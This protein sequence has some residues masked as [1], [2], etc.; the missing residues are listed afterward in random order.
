MWV[1]F[2]CHAWISARFRRTMNHL[3]YRCLPKQLLIQL[4][5]QSSQLLRAAVH[6]Q[7]MAALGVLQK[8]CHKHQLC[9]YSCVDVQLP[10]IVELKARSHCQPCCNA[11][12][13][14]SHPPLS[15]HSAL[16]CT[17]IVM[18]V[19][20]VAMAVLMSSCHTLLVSNLG[21]FFELCCNG[22]RKPSYLLLSISPRA[23]FPTKPIQNIDESF[24]RHHGFA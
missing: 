18:S 19:S 4:C 7:A 22:I 21:P 16:L 10:I 9:S 23:C 17:K 24:D 3:P 15:R 13:K 2:A 5:I 20:F 14:P 12:C 11:A 8:C 1:C 6:V